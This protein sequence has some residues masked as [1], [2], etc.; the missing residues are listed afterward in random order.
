MSVIQALGKLRQEG[1]LEFE[2]SLGYRQNETLSKRKMLIP[3]AS[4][5]G[6]G[7]E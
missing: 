3:E 2:A 7:V 1:P 6:R 4:A 5:V